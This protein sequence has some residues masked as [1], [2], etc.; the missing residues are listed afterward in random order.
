MLSASVSLLVCGLQ[1]RLMYERMR[2]RPWDPRHGPQRGAGPS[3]QGTLPGNRGPGW[4]GTS[5]G[6]IETPDQAGAPSTACLQKPWD[7]GPQLP[8]GYMHVPTVILQCLYCVYTVGTVTVGRV[9][10]LSHRGPGPVK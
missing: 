3:A 6:L 8:L 5:L 7:A 10:H 1:W 4:R 2:Q 9:Q